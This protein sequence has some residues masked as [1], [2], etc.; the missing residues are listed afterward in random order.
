MSFFAGHSRW[1]SQADGRKPALAPT[2]KQSAHRSRRRT[3]ATEQLR[4]TWAT[5]DVRGL[6]SGVAHDLNN[7]L[8]IVIGNL[9]VLYAARRDDDLVTELLADALE[10]AS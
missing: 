3:S 8:A 5:G 7:L 6:V 9:D 4:E 2:T 1:L 10:A